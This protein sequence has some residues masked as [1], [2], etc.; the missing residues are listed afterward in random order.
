MH[1]YA[2]RVEGKQA[3]EE[4]ETR[5]LHKDKSPEVIAIHKVVR[6]MYQNKPAIQGTIK[7]ITERKK[8]EE[9]LRRHKEHL[10]ELVAERT[11]EPGVQQRGAEQIYRAD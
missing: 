3:P 5:L 2:R 8:A 9:E 4:Y 1:Y 6:I 7:D 11:K 10:E